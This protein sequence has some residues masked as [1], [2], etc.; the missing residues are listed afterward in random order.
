MTAILSP[1]L[2]IPL[3]ML[4][5]TLFACNHVAA[6]IAFDHG[7]SVAA[8][9]AVR[10]GV[11][12]LVMVAL[13]QMRGIP[14]ALP[15][16]TLWRG[17]G[18]G[19]LVA[20]QS[21]CLYSAVAVIPV[22]L[23][24]LA[25]NTFPVLFVLLTWASGGEHPGRRAFVAMPLAL[26]GLVLAL[27]ILGTLEA[28]AG[29][30]A[31]IGVGVGWAFGAAASFALVLFFT[32]R[33]LKDVDGRVRTLLTMGTTAVV[34][35]LGGAAAHTLTRPADATGWIGLALLTALYGTAITSIF[36]VV[37]RLASPSNTAALNFEPIAALGLGW[38]VLAQTVEP[39]QLIGAFI[40]VGAVVL[41]GA[42]KH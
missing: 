16:A 35:G 22:A 27:D 32:T 12:A 23:A 33:H 14:M 11:T 15:R 4:L 40:V 9:V 17:L 6:R 28:M 1:R 21:Y 18:I 3:L 2:G 29:R 24:L 37:P 25:F 13:L 38:A 7:A 19:V 31:E 10:S 30:W 39:R 42:K 26:F 34:I 36:T 5:A 20:V 8:A 41:I